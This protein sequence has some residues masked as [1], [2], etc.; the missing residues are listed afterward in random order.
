MSKVQRPRFF[1]AGKTAVPANSDFF[2]TEAPFDK[3]K[4][5]GGHRE[6]Q[7]LMMIKA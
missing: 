4:A 6:G 1:H 5:G 7:R 3:L 2:T